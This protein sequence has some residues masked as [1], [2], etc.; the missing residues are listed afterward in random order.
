MPNGDPMRRLRPG[1]NPVCSAARQP[2]RS[3]DCVPM[4]DVLTTRHDVGRSA[5]RSRIVRFGFILGWCLWF[6][7]GSAFALFIDMLGDVL[8]SEPPDDSNFGRF[9]WSVIPPGP[10]CT[11]TKA[12][13]GYDAVRGPSPLMS[14]WII[15]VVVGAVITFRLIRHIWQRFPAEDP[16]SP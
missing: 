14:I 6:L 11:F 10:T 9:G 1:P 16:R 15:G 5:L 12:T 13:N 8:C 2:A 3:Y 7:A 4:A